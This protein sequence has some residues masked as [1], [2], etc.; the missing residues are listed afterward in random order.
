MMSLNVMEADSG[1][2]VMSLSALY[3]KVGS[4]VVVEGL[5][6]GLVSWL[7]AI[8]VSLP[9]SLIFNSMLGARCSG[10]HKPGVFHRSALCL[11]G[12]SY[13][14]L[15]Y[16][17][18][19]AAYRAMRMSVGKPCLRKKSRGAPYPPSSC[20]ATTFSRSLTF[21]LLPSGCFLKPAH[22]LN[23]RIRLTLVIWHPVAKSGKICNLQQVY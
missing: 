14:H 8:P 1:I 23:I 7:I 16:R 11:A 3:R 17:Q 2:G 15:F 5:I 21:R 4:I 6:I 22:L 19:A 10:S 12:Y 20:G 13:R 18:S 9:V